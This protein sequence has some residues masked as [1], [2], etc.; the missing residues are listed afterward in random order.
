MSKDKVN[1]F[2]RVRGS[3]GNYH[4]IEVKRRTTPFLRLS[5]GSIV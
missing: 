3:P 2:F 1:I 5:Q 4:L